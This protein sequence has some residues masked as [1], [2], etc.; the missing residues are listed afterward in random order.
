MQPVPTHLET[1]EDQAALRDILKAA[2]YGHWSYAYEST[3]T[4]MKRGVRICI[5]SDKYPRAGSIASHMIEEA[6]IDIR[7]KNVRCRTGNTVY[8]K[9]KPAYVVASGRAR[10]SS[11]T[12]ADVVDCAD[13]H[14]LIEKVLEAA[15]ALKGDDPVNSSNMGRGILQN[16]ILDNLKKR[17]LA[18][19]KGLHI[20]FGS[21]SQSPEKAASLRIKIPTTLK[22][23][24][25]TQYSID[26]LVIIL[27]DGSVDILLS[28]WGDYSRCSKEK[29]FTIPYFSD[30]KFDP[31]LFY[32][33]VM[34]AIKE[35]VVL[36]DLCCSR[37]DEI[38]RLINE[39]SEAK[40]NKRD[41]F[42]ETWDSLWAGN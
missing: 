28:N 14:D 12:S 23:N 38:D 11:C 33:F 42:R 39:I 16:L 40:N 3:A 17:L 9:L 24:G 32:T 27:S 30:P 18:S 5:K 35:M 2:G 13:A 31:E 36:R 25:I 6:T 1:E 7:T 34:A 4:N 29:K 20:Q 41:G 15:K 22:A 10:Y 26:E 8:K 19:G 37:Q 21:R